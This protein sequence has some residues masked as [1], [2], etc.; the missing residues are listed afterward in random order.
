MCLHLHMTILQVSDFGLSRV[1]LT[2]DVIMT[3]TCGTVWK[4]YPTNKM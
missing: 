4:Q 3:N 1:A 2:D